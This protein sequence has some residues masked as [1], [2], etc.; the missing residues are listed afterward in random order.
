MRGRRRNRGSDVGRSR[1]ERC[2]LSR[3]RVHTHLGAFRGDG[4]S[5]IKVERGN[6]RAWNVLRLGNDDVKA[7]LAWVDFDWFFEDISWY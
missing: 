3:G 6:G 2:K 7:G 5:E 4:F 1:D